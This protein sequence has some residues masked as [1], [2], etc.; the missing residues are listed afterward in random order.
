VFFTGHLLSAPWTLVTYPLLG[1]CGALCMLFSCYWLWWAGGSLE[2]SWGSRTFGLFFFGMSALSAFAIWLG[3]MVTRVEPLE[4]GGLLLPLAGVTIAF[5]MLNPEQEILFFFIIPMKLKY[6]AL[7]DVVLVFISYGQIHL[8]LGVF[9]LAGC[10]FSYWYVR[11]GS[12]AGYG[13]NRYEDREK[14]IRLHSRP[15]IGRRL[16]PLRWYSNYRDRKKFRDFL[17][18]SGFG[19]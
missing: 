12:L 13:S 6:L 16:N 9:A 17:N 15:G 18:K 8:L 5:A 19:E 11:R 2:R 14:V 3:V 1:L 7:L 10:A 4:I